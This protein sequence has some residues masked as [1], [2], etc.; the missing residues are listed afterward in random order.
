MSCI[1][2]LIGAL[3]LTASNPD[4]EKNSGETGL[5]RV[6]RWL[7]EI[8]FL[9]LNEEDVLDKFKKF[10]ESTLNLSVSL[11]KFEFDKSDSA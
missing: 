1:K 2:A 7:A 3:F 8:K 11:N 5:Y 4:R 9:P 6:V 10:S